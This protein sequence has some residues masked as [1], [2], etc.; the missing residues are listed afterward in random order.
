LANKTT[1]LQKVEAIL[2]EPENPSLGAYSKVAA[3]LALALTFC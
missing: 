1:C 3:D 2:K